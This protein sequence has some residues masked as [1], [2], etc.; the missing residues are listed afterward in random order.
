L[1]AAKVRTAAPGRYCDGDGLYLL[2]RSP[3]T[4]FWVF[5]FTRARKMREMGLGRARGRNAVALADARAKA[6]ALHRLVRSGVDPLDQREAETAAAQ[7]AA[8]AEVARA[9]TFRAVARFYLDAHEAAWRNS[10]H[11]QQWENTL[12]TYAYPH[13]GDLPV[14]AVGTAHVLAALQPIWQ[15][16]PETAARV[17]GGSRRPSIT[18][19]RANGGMAR[20]RRGGAGTWPISCRHAA[21][22]R[23]SSTTPPWHGGRSAP[24]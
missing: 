12:A 9:I 1:S 3:E 24:S 16:K 4:A 18:P 21:R 15:G 23:P 10:K 2:V 19:R 22:S 8:Q 7:A 13:V 11:R 17:R 6:S 14:A 5:R 20:T